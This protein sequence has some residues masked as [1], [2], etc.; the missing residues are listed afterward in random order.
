MRG[1]WREYRHWRTKCTGVWRRC[2]GIDEN[3][4]TGVEVKCNCRVLVRIQ[5]LEIEVKQAYLPDIAE[6]IMVSGY[7]P[8][9]TKIYSG[10]S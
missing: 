9:L 2:E 4:V 10:A 8:M 3:A 6:D 1:Y 7:N 5:A